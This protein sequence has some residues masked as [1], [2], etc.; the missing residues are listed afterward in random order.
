MFDSLFQSGFK[1]VLHNVKDFEG[2]SPQVIA[3]TTDRFVVAVCDIFHSGGEDEVI[4]LPDLAELSDVLL[5]AADADGLPGAVLQGDGKLFQ[6]RYADFLA[7]ASFR[8]HIFYLHPITCTH[9]LILIVSSYSSGG[10]DPSAYKD[11]HKNM[12]LHSVVFVDRFHRCRYTF[13]VLTGNNTDGTSVRFSDFA[14]KLERREFPPPGSQLV[15]ATHPTQAVR[16]VEVL[17]YCLVDNTTWPSIPFYMSPHSGSDLTTSQQVFNRLQSSLRQPIEQFWAD[18]TNRFAMFR[19]PVNFHRGE[20]SEWDVRVAKAIIASY[21]LHNICLDYHDDILAEW[22]LPPESES[23]SE[24]DEEEALVGQ[25][26][27]TIR[28]AL[29]LHA[30]DLYR[31]GPKRQLI[32]RRVREV[33]ALSTRDSLAIPSQPNFLPGPVLVRNWQSVSVVASDDSAIRCSFSILR[34]SH[35]TQAVG[36]VGVWSQCVVLSDQ[37]SPHPRTRIHHSHTYTTEGRRA[38]QVAGDTRKNTGHFKSC[39]RHKRESQS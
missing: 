13:D 16:G 33:T 14:G 25:D 34:D 10:Y 2:I 30:N 39:R 23:E 11:W 17:P 32:R 5:P 26:L 29:E 21:C 1:G 36:G 24:S 22:Q 6:V 18:V 4:R 19:D 3:K 35:V 15:L 12:S 27:A 20:A 31:L 28:M 9:S 7:F 8:M 38:H 37:L